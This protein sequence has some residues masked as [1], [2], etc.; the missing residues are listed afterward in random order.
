M[1]EVTI[2][3]KLNSFLYYVNKLSY[4]RISWISFFPVVLPIFPKSQVLLQTSR[5]FPLHHSTLTASAHPYLIGQALS[6]KHVSSYIIQ[7]YI[8]QPQQMSTYEC[9][10]K[11]FLAC[12]DYD[13]EIFA[14]NHIESNAFPD[15]SA[16]TH[17]AIKNTIHN[18]EYPSKSSREGISMRHISDV[19]GYKFIYYGIMERVSNHWPLT[20]H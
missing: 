14:E 19:F 3:E 13:E 11:Q 5:I 20:L 9:P 15:E 8:I 17:I 18:L 16:R 12:S 10:L 6:F 7:T 4:L 1:R 2:S